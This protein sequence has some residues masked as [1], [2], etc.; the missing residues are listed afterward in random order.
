MKDKTFS[1]IEIKILEAAREVF[2]KKGFEATKMSDI[3][4]AAGISRTSLNYYFRTKE[5]LFEAIFEQVVQTFAP[6]MQAIADEDISMLGKVDKI[7]G[8]YMRMLQTNQSLPSFIIGE[9]QRDPHHLMRVMGGKLEEKPFLLKLVMQIEQ[10]MAEGKLRRMPLIDVVSTLLGLIV[11][12]LMI[13]N[14]LVPM[15]MDDDSQRFED[16]LRDR[17]QLVTRVMVQLLTP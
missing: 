5:R 12:P 1:E 15:F 7:V 17:H 9:I 2:V 10:E 3:S 6:E 14:V 4:L 8:Q 11:F 16:F 13:K